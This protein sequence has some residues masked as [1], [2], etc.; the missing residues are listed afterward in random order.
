MDIRDEI[1]CLGKLE[2]GY[3]SLQYVK[4]QMD[5]YLYEPST[6]ALFETKEYLKDKIA[7]LVDTNET[8]L[9]YLKRTNDLV[10]DQYRLVKFHIK[11]IFDLEY[12]VMEYTI[13]SRQ[14]S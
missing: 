12:D 10:P 3:N 14:I 7:A 6:R 1:T 8:M 13:K 4:A 11:E 5:S 2:R 9:D